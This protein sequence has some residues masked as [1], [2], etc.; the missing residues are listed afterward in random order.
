MKCIFC[1]ADTSNSKSVEHIIPQS[2]GNS[3]MVLRRGIV[4]DKCNNYFSVEIENPFLSKESSKM[5]RR[6]LEIKS[7]KGK[8]PEISGF[9]NDIT[10]IKQISPD[11]FLYIDIDKDATEEKIAKTV[12][13]FKSYNKVIEQD[14]IKKDKNTCRLLAK[15]A[16]EYFVFLLNQ[17]D[18]VC[19]YVRTDPAFKN[20]IQFVRF[21]PKIDWDYNVR[22][23]YELNKFH[24][25]VLFD[26]I[27]W[28]CDFLFTEEGEIYYIVIM[29]GI[30]YA[31]NLGGSSVEGYKRWLDKYH[32]ISP[33]YLPREE[34]ESNFKK[35][36][37]KVYS[38]NDYKEFLKSLDDK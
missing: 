31:I 38:D 6:E 34:R 13:S 4:C 15:M 5:L 24:E 37:R 9:P 11:T 25:D 20:I 26:E 23:Y 3:K 7:K 14:A 19:D 32:N 16:V 29:F 27:N 18:D 2:F 17:S 35:Y 22:R 30:E 36:A 8:I 10:K 12:E 28:E 33:L 1:N 21:N